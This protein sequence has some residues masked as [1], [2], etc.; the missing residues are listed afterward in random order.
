MPGSLLEST[1]GSVLE[2]AEAFAIFIL[3]AVILRHW[4]EFYRNPANAGAPSVMVASE[5]AWPRMQR[6]AAGKLGAVARKN[7]SAA[8]PGLA[9][10]AAQTETAFTNE[11]SQRQG[12]AVLQANARSVFASRESGF[13]RL[14]PPIV[15]EAANLVEAWPG[16]H[17][18][19]ELAPPIQTSKPDTLLGEGD[20][21]ISRPKRTPVVPLLE[22]LVCA[23]F[24]GLCCLTRRLR[25][26][27]RGVARRP[28][29]FT[30]AAKRLL[31]S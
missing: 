7:P 6:H 22:A 11:P 14:G 10:V 26:P 19:E 15:P 17:V 21:A 31:W 12:E 8:L 28:R 18:A 2:S 13:P 29:V 9:E 16:T 30:R 3:A 20:M 24:G 4:L 23:V 1:G 27:N 25:S 5:Q